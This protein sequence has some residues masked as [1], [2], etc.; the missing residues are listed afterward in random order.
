[1]LGLGLGGSLLAVAALVIWI[2][3]LVWLAE[4]IMH[5]IGVKTGWRPLDLRTLLTVTLL[6][7]GAIHFGNYAVDW[8]EA[9]L[10]EGSVAPRLTVPS[11]FLIGSVAISVGIAGIR[12]HRK[13]K[14][15]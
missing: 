11:A 2:I 3:I 4:R 5:F 1:M 14:R 12:W 15:K 8:I 10:S 13:Q 6:L 9:S 7:G